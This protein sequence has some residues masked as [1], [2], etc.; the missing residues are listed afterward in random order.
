MGVLLVTEHAKKSIVLAPGTTGEITGDMTKDWVHGPQFPIR[1]D[2][3]EE[4]LIP[5]RLLVSLEAVQAAARDLAAAA[6]SAQT[7]TCPDTPAWNERAPSA[8]ETVRKDAGSLPS[9]ARRLRE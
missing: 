1:S 5:A 7:K 4:R 2:S 6:E 8:T 9:L 3:G